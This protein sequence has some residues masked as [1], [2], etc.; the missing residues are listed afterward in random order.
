MNDLCCPLLTVFIH[1]S[2]LF[3]AHSHAETVALLVLRR[4][5]FNEYEQLSGGEFNYIYDSAYFLAEFL[6]NCVNNPHALDN[7][8]LIKSDQFDLA[9]EVL[10]TL[11]ER[12]KAALEH[13]TYPEGWDLLGNDQCKLN[14]VLSLCSF[15]KLNKQSVALL[16]N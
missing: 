2:C 7:L 13:A 15:H 10:S 8:E 12:L 3:S 9:N 14:P 11:D 5:S 1:L 4:V 16:I 6:V